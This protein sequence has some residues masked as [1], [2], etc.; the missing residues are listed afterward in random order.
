MIDSRL[1]AREDGEGGVSVHFIFSGFGTAMV[2]K[3]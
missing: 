3:Q 2:R 1:C